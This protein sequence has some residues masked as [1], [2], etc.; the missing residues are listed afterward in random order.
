MFTKKNLLSLHSASGVK[1]EY[2]FL[3][4]GK[5][6]LYKKPLKIKNTTLVEY[7]NVGAVE[8]DKTQTIKKNIDLKVELFHPYNS[9]YTAGGPS[10]LV[11]GQRG[12]EDFRTGGWQ[13]YAGTD[14]AAVVDLGKKQIIRRITLGCLQEARS[15]IWLP[16]SVEYYYSIDGL[17]YIKLGSLGH[18]IPDTDLGAYLMDFS[19]DFV[20]VEARYIKVFAKN[21]GVCPNWHIGKGGKAWIFVDE[22]I[23]E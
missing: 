19:L 17:N 3:P 8:T 23:I 2:R 16:T 7:R 18:N 10:G 9:Q 22:I 4:D 13:G 6:K 14:F 21:Y 20:P 12:G 5:W 11:D 15:W 1:I